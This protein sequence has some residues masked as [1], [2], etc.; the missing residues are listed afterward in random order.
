MHKKLIKWHLYAGLLCF[1]YF[2]IF[3]ISSLNFN[4]HFKFMEPGKNSSIWQKQI[5]IP[6]FKDDDQFSEGVKDSLHLMGWTLPWEVKKDSTGFQFKV[7]HPGKEYSIKV[8]RNENTVSVEETSMGFWPVFN[9]LH[10]FDG[11][12]PGSSSIL[13][14]MWGYY[15]SITVVVM[16]FSIISGIYIFLRRKNE[17]KTGLI[18]LF[19]CIGLS[20]LI[21]LFAWL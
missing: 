19:S 14:S 21:M 4:H 2:I 11:K 6:P 15:Q 7:T 20:L 16:L 3:G 9:A 10:G 13:I 17:R 1:P 8:P 5:N 18:I 12:I